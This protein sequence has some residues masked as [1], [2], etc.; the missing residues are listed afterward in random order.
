VSLKNV[1]VWPEASSKRLKLE[2]YAFVLAL[3]IAR[4]N[5]L[6]APSAKSSMIH[7]PD[8]LEL[9]DVSLHL[10]GWSILDRHMTMCFLNW[11]YA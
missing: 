8:G 1:S 3:C 11:I 10:D 7:G 6:Q 4:Y 5:Q 9:L 2:D